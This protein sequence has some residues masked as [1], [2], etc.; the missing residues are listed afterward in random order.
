MSLAKQEKAKDKKKKILTT[1]LIIM[2]IMI[3][4]AMAAIGWIYHKFNTYQ[5][6]ITD[7]NIMNHINVT[8]DVSIGKVQLH[9][10]E[11]AAIDSVLYEEGFNKVSEDKIKQTA[12]MFL[13][14]SDN[15]DLKYRSKDFEDVLKELKID[16]LKKK[17]ALS[18][19]EKLNNVGIVSK[20]L[21]QD[22][23][24]KKFVEELKDEAIAIYKEFNILPSIS[25]AQAAL[26]SGWGTS[27]LSTK[28][29]NLFGIKADVYW[30]GEKVHMETSE[31]YNDTITDPF[32]SYESKKESLDDYV[33]FLANNERYKKHGVFEAITYKQQAKA[34]QDAGYSTK[35]NEA[36]ELIYA[37]MLGELIRSNDLQLIDYEA[38]NGKSANNAISD[39]K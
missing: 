33:S 1:I 16:G 36:G 9:W 25:I 23:P 24:N 28:N 29:N 4:S 14:E 27:E 31:N 21:V 34:L 8:D 12:N 15:G 2:F 38:M 32:R 22:S 10:K 17:R 5:L 3:L 18:N 13:E 35:K 37:E 20:N 39:Q 26:E 7:P 11:V 19:L 6:I 30:N